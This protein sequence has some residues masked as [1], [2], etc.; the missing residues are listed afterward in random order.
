MNHLVHSSH[1][2][3]HWLKDIQFAVGIVVAIGGAAVVL[4]EVMQLLS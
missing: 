2:G 4:S 1:A 3:H